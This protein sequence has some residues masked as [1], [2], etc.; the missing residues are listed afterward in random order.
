[1]KAG[2]SCPATY[3]LLVPRNSQTCPKKPFPRYTDLRNEKTK[4]KTEYELDWMIDMKIT[5]NGGFC[6]LVFQLSRWEDVLLLRSLNIYRGEPISCGRKQ[7]AGFIP[8][9]FAKK[10]G[11]VASHDPVGG[12]HVSA[13]CK[14]FG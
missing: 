13:R 1:L 9:E 14:T 6:L 7:P 2:L 5:R 4:T 11:A 10:L 12:W 8:A 3:T